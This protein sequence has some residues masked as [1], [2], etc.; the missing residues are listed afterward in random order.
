MDEIHFYCVICGENLVAEQEHAGGFC[1]CPRC[2][3]GIPVPG[4]PARPG[5]SPAC[6]EAF[7]ADILGIELKFLCT[8]CSN[9]VQVD[10]RHRRRT[11][12]CP[13][14]HEPTVVPDWS[15]AVPPLSPAEKGMPSGPVVRITEEE[16]DFLTTPLHPRGITPRGI[17]AG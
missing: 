5:E 12:E 17:V 1:S 16:R 3:R 7:P 14:C 4:F 6:G 10:A 8:H 2:L 15:G 11:L 9:K 13:V